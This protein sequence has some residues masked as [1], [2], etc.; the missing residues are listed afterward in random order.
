MTKTTKTKP[1]F[2]M[3]EERFKELR[4]KGAESDR[5][6]KAGFAGYYRPTTLIK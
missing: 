5:K 2:S 1:T 6:R 3:T 4:A